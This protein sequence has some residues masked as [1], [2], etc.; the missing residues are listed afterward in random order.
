MYTI[1]ADFGTGGI[2]VKLFATA[3]T[4]GAKSKTQFNFKWM[5]MLCLL[6]IPVVLVTVLVQSSFSR[7]MMD[8]LAEMNVTFAANAKAN[9]DMI[10]TILLNYALSIYFSNEVKSLRSDTNPGNLKVIQGVRAMNN[11]TA[12]YSFVESVYIYNAS[13]RYIYST[14][15]LLGTNDTLER[16]GDR[17][18]AE[19]FQNLE[20]YPKLRPFFRAAEYGSPRGNKFVYS[21][22]IASQNQNSAMMI[23]LSSE[24]LNELILGNDQHACLL[25]ADGKILASQIEIGDAERTAV[26]KMLEARET[27]SGHFLY[28][29]RGSARRVCFFAD[30]GPVGWRYLRL[31]NYDDCIGGQMKVQRIAYGFVLAVLITAC[32]LALVLLLRVV[33]PFR[34]LNTVMTDAG[35]AP[36]GSSHMEEMTEKLDRL[37]S[38]S[39]RAEHIESAFN[40]M[41]RNE[42]LYNVLT[43][44]VEAEEGLNQYSLKV[45]LYRP[46]M[47]F[48]I[49][50]VNIKKYMEAL[51]S[52]IQGAEGINV[53]GRHSVLLVQAGDDLSSRAIAET[54]L[55]SR[56]TGLVIYGEI[57][58][59]PHQLQRAYRH[60][61]RMYSRRCF[62]PG[63]R[64]L[65]T[66]TLSHLT[67]D[68]QDLNAATHKLISALKSGNSTAEKEQ[69][70]KML[71]LLADKKFHTA[72]AHLISVYR[73]MLTLREEICPEVD[74]DADQQAAVFEALL[75]DP[76]SLDGVRKALDELAQGL[77]SYAR[78]EKKIQHETL[79]QQITDYID[80][81]Y[82]DPNLNSQMLADHFHISTAYLCRIFRK[83]NNQS[84]AAY[85]TRQRITRACEML[86]TTD[87]PIKNISCAVGLDNSQY[88]YVQ[89]KHQMGMTPNEFRAQSNS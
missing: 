8:T 71:D 26:L 25:D 65:N 36:R 50:G 88:F 64:L 4:K 75:T 62:Y 20:Q 18:A 70:Q 68:T 79:M 21:Y 47:L 83:E 11:M 58:S 61:V 6:L 37:I 34:K 3:W 1:S 14:S 57:T 39:N 53:S 67:D 2:C 27:G 24:W 44:D 86:R 40:D 69:I 85:I 12:V 17:T 33:F 73:A 49:N 84:L 87:E 32:L 66:E 89:F 29:F 72:I 5:K 35:L 38:L 80:A 54:L 63:Q 76:D 10:N 51:P 19:I 46:V 48:Y 43:G 41:L 59:H 60:L 77:V 74:A 31:M 42:T 22:L 45:D 82:A 78:Q 16:F 81:T 7:L 28:S 23:N 15:D 55:S 56:P 13:S 9:T 30:M 52:S